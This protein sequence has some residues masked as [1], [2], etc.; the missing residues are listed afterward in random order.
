MLEHRESCG[1]TE[2]GWCSYC[3]ELWKEAYYK[4]KKDGVVG[5]KAFMCVTD[6]EYDLESAS[7]GCRIY[8]SETDLKKH[9]KC[10]AECGIVEVEVTL[11]KEES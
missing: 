2:G 6:Y 11:K 5:K 8:P 10:W 7:G 1:H 3:I 4:G 9:S